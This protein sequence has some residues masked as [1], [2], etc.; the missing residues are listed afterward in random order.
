M[1]LRPLEPTDASVPC[2]GP[3]PDLGLGLGL[4]QSI[5]MERVQS[6]VQEMG[7]SLSPGAQSLMDM[8]Q[9]QQ[10]VRTFQTAIQSDLKRYIWTFDL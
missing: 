7:T 4:G 10:K 1:G 8:V 5:D 9:I 2:P 3:G 6:M